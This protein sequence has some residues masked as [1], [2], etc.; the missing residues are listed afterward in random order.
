MSRFT[1]DQVAELI[2]ARDGDYDD[3]TGAHVQ[4]RTDPADCDESERTLRIEL[5]DER[6]ASGDG[7]VED[8]V[9]TVPRADE[10][11]L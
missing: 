9:I 5:E 8:F 3:G 11:G 10:D 2:A 6:L 4:V 7:A 1:L